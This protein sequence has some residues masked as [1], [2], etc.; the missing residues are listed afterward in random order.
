MCLLSD[1]QDSILVPDLSCDIIESANGVQKISMED[2]RKL[3]ISGNVDLGMKK[4]VQSKKTPAAQQNITTAAQ[5]K[6]TTAASFFKSESI[7]KK[8]KPSRNRSIPLEENPKKGNADD[9]VGDVDEDD[10]FLK[11]EEERKKRN[12]V[13][14]Q[15]E[16]LKRKMNENRLEGRASKRLSGREKIE[17]EDESEMDDKPDKEAEKVGAIDAFASKKIEVAQGASS[18]KGNKRKKQVLEEKTFIDDNGFL[19]TETVTVL[20]D[21]EDS[22]ATSAMITKNKGKDATKSKLKSSKNMKQQGLM[23][24]FSKKK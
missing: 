16:R 23:G 10:E 12:A 9:F 3:R 21:V 18:L 8:K 5:K 14:V 11:E 6:V 2:A 7:T 17:L 24:F 13:H 1:H 20:K 19:R 15:N 4:K 22:E